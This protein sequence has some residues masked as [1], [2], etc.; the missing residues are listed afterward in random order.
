MRNREGTI[1]SESYISP[2]LGRIIL[3]IMLNG[4]WF[5]PLGL[6]NIQPKVLALQ[7]TSIGYILW[8]SFISYHALGGERGWEEGD[9][10]PLIA[11]NITRTGLAIE[12]VQHR[13]LFPLSKYGGLRSPRNLIELYVWFKPAVLKF[14]NLMAAV[15][16]V[17]V[18]HKT[19]HAV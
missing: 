3:G 13:W 12:L 17:I 14:Q 10:Y 6:G 5:L 18:I 19:I 8:K 9:E 1:T 4:A 11:M 15:R 2:F 7:E 16:Q